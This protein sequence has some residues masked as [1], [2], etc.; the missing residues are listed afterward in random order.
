MLRFQAI[1]SFEPPELAPYRTMRMQHEHWVQ[2]IFVAEGA[3]VVRRL[4]ASE[5]EVL[6]VLLP[7]C[8]ADELRPLLEARAESIQVYTAEKKLLEQLTGYSMYQGL[9]AVGRIPAPLTVDTALQRSPRPRLFAAVDG[10]SNAENVGALVRSAVAFNV[11]G[12][13]VGE[14]SSSP[15][16]RRAVRSSMGTVFQLPIVETNDLVGALRQLRSK[17]V[18]CVAAHPHTDGRTIAQ[19]ELA[20]DCCVVLGNEGQG[21][22]P[23]VQAACDEC[24]AIPMPPTVDS[25]NVASAAAVFLYEANRQRGRM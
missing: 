5:L 4:L 15:Y 13:V 6:S 22:A 17:G 12:L 21:I 24:I 25:L 18:R 14:T 19:A 7:A 1:D 23:A 9:L 10:L 3:P 16:L 11:Q 20:V 8:W 2:R